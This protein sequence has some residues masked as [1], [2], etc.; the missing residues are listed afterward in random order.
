MKSH[1]YKRPLEG[2]IPIHMPKNTGT[3]AI[4]G[5]LSIVF[6]FAMVWHIWWLAIAGFA[7]MIIVTI[8][9]TFNYNRDFYIPAADV[10][11]VEARRTQLLPAE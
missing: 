6:G 7:A 5:A 1:G 2:F 10:A 4:L 11:A 9:H 8:R 3:G